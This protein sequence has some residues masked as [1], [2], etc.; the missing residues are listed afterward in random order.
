MVPLSVVMECD[1]F[2]PETIFG[3]ENLVFSIYG[4]VAHEAEWS[5][6]FS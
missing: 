4:Y 3:V 2:D 1:G 5:S 6:R